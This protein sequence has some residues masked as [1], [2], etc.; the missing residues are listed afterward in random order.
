MPVWRLVGVALGLAVYALASHWLMLHAAHR[1]WAIAALSGPLLAVLTGLAIRRRHA[2]SLFACAALVS[3][4]GAVVAR[5]GVD[6]V[7]RLYLLQHVG[8]HLAL[9]WTFGATL[10]RGSTALITGFAEQVHGVV[11]TAMRAYTRRLTAIWV[12]YFVGM[13]A[14]SLVL[15]A[16]APWSWWSLFANLMTPLA[17]ATL[18]VGEYLLRFHW[19]PEFERSSIMQSLS[20]YRQISASG[21]PPR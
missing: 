10:R 17:A 9:A 1:P 13:A 3:L 11:S 16:A 14:I 19:H 7:N 21:E 18:F 5:G 2:P 15:F 8:F 6:D 20:A 4:V 12:G